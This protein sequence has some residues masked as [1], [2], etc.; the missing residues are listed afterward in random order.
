MSKIGAT[1]FDEMAIDIVD[2]VSDYVALMK[3][4]FDFDLLR[5]FF[6]SR[7]SFR[8]LFDGMHGGNILIP[9]L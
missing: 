3:T 7:P 4:V 2:S 9:L 6:A 5:S 8:L 1:K